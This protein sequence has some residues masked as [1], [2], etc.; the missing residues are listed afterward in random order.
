MDPP[1]RHSV[2]Y[3][4]D[5]DQNGAWGAIVNQT[6]ALDLG[7]IF[8][9]L[10]IK[11]ELP[12]TDES[13]LFGGPVDEQHG[14]VLHPSGKQYESTREFHAGISV[15]SSRDVLEAMAASDEPAK[16]LVLL[17]HSGWA[18]GQLESEIAANAWLTC[19]ADSTVL[20]DTPV[21]QRRNAVADL[22]GVNLDTIVGDSG[23]A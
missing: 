16:R 5:H 17:G 12:V 22:I 6:S 2:V 23:H 3:L 11:T 20:F 19:E 13:V 9:Q 14:V 21:E 10:D 4:I 7:D 15:S 1:F 8:D 18:A